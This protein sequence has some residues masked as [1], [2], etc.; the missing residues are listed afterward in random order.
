MRS[1]AALCFQVAPLLAATL[2]SSSGARAQ[3]SATAAGARLE[4]ASYAAN[5]EL[6]FPADA[7]TWVVLGTSLG[8]DYAEG[9][10]DPQNPGT[11]GVVQIEPSA[12][13]RVL[14]TGAYPDGTML[15]LTFYRAEAQSEPQLQGFVQG[16]MRGREIHVI[17][18]QRFPAEG[19][20][21]FVY[22]RTDTKSA[23]PSPAGSECVRCHS[24]HGRFDATFVQFYPPFRH[25]ASR[26]TVN[27]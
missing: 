12:Y 19:R 11:I 24:E 9:A 5:G 3:P 17:D 14:E 26:E 22:T 13:G 16:P 2:L 25:L 15:L 6:T 23:A 18:K 21:F 7:D 27:P 8:S 1:T 4:V 20:A 10:F